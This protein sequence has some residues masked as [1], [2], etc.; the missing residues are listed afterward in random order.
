MGQ[1]QGG[2]LNLGCGHG[3]WR[4][5]NIRN[6]SCSPVPLHPPVLISST[7]RT[8]D[9]LGKNYPFLKGPGK[10]VEQTWLCSYSEFS[11]KTVRNLKFGDKG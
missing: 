3:L 8:I 1:V 7:K 10:K 2:T 5:Q 4:L 11:L 6:S 9:I